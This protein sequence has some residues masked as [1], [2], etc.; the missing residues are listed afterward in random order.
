LEGIK[1]IPKEEVR[2]PDG[3][4]IRPTPEII[5]WNIGLK[6]L[7]SMPMTPRYC[8]QYFEP[9]PKKDMTTSI[10]SEKQMEIVNRIEA[11]TS[12]LRLYKQG[13]VGH[14]LVFSVKIFK[15][16]ESPVTLVEFFRYG[17]MIPILEASYEIQPTEINDLI[18]FWKD[19]YGKIRFPN[20]FKDKNLKWALSRFNLATLR[21]NPIEK[22]LDLIITFEILFTSGRLRL[23]IEVATFLAK[24]GDEWVKIYDDV[25]EGY[26]LRS[27][28]VHG[29]II[30]VKHEEALHSLLPRLEEYARLALRKAID[31][32]ETKKERHG[33]IWQNFKIN[34]QVSRTSDSRAG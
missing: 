32:N 23:A 3:L 30:K 9:L 1:T 8:L 29:E 33:I 24:K 34:K 5:E 18:S 7:F 21:F 25:Y 27:K 13:R 14:N 12:L 16:E 11:T 19:Y 2:F 22:I 10:S 17:S 26:D 4:L 6:C 20:E 28:I 31:L 15:H